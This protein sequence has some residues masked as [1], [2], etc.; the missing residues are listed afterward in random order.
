[1]NGSADG[2]RSWLIG[3]QCVSYSGV[4]PNGDWDLLLLRERSKLVLSPAF[5]LWV[6]P[7][8]VEEHAQG[9][10]HSGL[11]ECVWDW[12][13]RRL[14]GRGLPELLRHDE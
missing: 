7:D 2:P 6:G 3:A 14:E 8:D 9:A 13:F 1:M 12:S 5:I 11:C 4:L 10:D